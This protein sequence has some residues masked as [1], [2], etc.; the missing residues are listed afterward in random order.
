MAGTGPDDAHKNLYQDSGGG[1]ASRKGA[2][3]STGVL[4]VQFF[5]SQPGHADRDYLAAKAASYLTRVDKLGV[6]KSM[7]V[8]Q[9]SCD[10]H[11][12]A[13]NGDIAVEDHDLTDHAPPV[14]GQHG[15]ALSEYAR[16]GHTV[17]D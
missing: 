7:S 3:K 6:A 17:Q 4:Q 14:Q 5:H 11:D 15:F 9:A 16:S 2:G 12:I 13:S 10:A 1:K 8:A